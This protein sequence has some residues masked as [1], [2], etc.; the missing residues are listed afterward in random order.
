MK[1]T[2][3]K[4][5]KVIM[6]NA[7]AERIYLLMESEK[8]ELEVIGQSGGKNSSS[9]IMSRTHVDNLERNTA[10]ISMSLKLPLMVWLMRF[11]V[12]YVHRQKENL[13]IEN[14]FLDNRFSP[15]DEN[16]YP[17]KVKSVLC[18]PLVEK[19]SFSGILYLVKD[20]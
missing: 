10:E 20:N 1:L 6:E 12:R 5:I 16:S 15:P 8:N 13:L 17:T 18:L 2:W 4:V 9:M 3:I 14:A 11:V 7:A 19:R